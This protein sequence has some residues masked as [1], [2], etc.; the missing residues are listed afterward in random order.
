MDCVVDLFDQTTSEQLPMPDADVWL[1]RK[2][3]LGRDSEY[4]LNT[5]I[6]ETPW[7]AETITLWGKSMPQPRL[8]AWYGDPD[9]N[10]SYSGIKLV[11]EKWTDTLLELR[12]Y[13]ENA[14][15]T[16]FNSVLLNYYRDNKDSMG[17]HS[18]DERELGKNPVIASLSLGDQRVFILK[19][20]RRSD[21]N[22]IKL[23]LPDAS[24]IVMKGSTQRHWKHGIAKETKPCGPRVNLTFRQIIRQ[25]RLTGAHRN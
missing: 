3:E 21:I 18:D 17:L 11:P 2:L 12:E 25:T 22:A 14:S 4:F 1:T 23:P 5:L 20:K 24:L 15:G 13:V 8:T 7:R 19:H 9:L 6:A 10:Y 16:S